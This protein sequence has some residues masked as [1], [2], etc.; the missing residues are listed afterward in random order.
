MTT[1]ASGEMK[2][3]LTIDLVFQKG[4]LKNVTLK[5]AWGKIQLSAPIQV[6]ISTS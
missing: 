1:D 4:D 6:P 2:E 3:K 5:I